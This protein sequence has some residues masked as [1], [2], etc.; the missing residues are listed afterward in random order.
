[1]EKKY[2]LVLID[3][4]EQYNEMVK[5]G[6]AYFG[7]MN[8]SIEKLIEDA[9]RPFKKATDEYIYENDLFDFEDNCGNS[10]NIEF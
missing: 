4:K 6:G 8:E 10:C 5:S 7:R 9:K 1:M 2:S 3:G